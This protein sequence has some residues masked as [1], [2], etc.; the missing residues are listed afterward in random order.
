MGLTDVGGDR[1]RCVSARQHFERG[2]EAVQKSMM[3]QI[4]LLLWPEGLL[5]PK[6]NSTATAPEEQL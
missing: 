1:C 6:E 5:Q 3:E 2:R 4:N